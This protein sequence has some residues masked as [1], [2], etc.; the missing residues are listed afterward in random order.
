MVVSSPAVG[1]L[2]RD[3][4]LDVVTGRGLLTIGTLL[5]PLNFLAMAN[6][7]RGDPGIVTLGAE[8]LTGG[9]FVVVVGLA[10]RVLVPAGRWPKGCCRRDRPI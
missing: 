10:A 2:D 8:L 7:G 1:D 3:S 6:L 5:V 4:V 9:I